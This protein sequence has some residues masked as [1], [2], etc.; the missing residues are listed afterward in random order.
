MLLLRVALGWQFLEEGLWKLDKRNNFSSAGY[1]SQAKGPLAEHYRS[2]VPD[3]YDWETL[4][5]VQPE[6]PPTSGTEWHRLKSNEL[7]AM[8]KR[9][10]V[11]N[12]LSE[13]QAKEKTEKP[14]DEATKKLDDLV[15]ENDSAI[16]KYIKD[17]RELDAQIDQAKTAGDHAK[18][19][20]LQAD[21]QALEDQAKSWKSKVAR[22]ERDLRNALPDTP[23]EAPYD[24]WNVG[25]IEAWND[26]YDQA[27][28]HYGYDEATQDKAQAALASAREELRDFFADEHEAV[29]EYLRESKALAES[30][31]ENGSKDVPFLQGRIGDKERELSAQATAWKNK[32]RA[33]E[34]EYHNKL[35]RLADGY[36]N[37]EA[38]PQEKTTLEKFDTFMSYSLVAIG[39]CLVLGLFTRLASLGG[40]VFLLNVA[41]AQPNFPWL[42]PPIHP[43]IGHSLVTKEVVEML[44]MAFMACTTIGRV[45]GVDFFIHALVTGRCCRKGK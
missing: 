8:R 31:K 9:Y 18:L 41:L 34:S 40:A 32:V 26:F 17:S 19:E 11:F 23:A 25:V 27:V 36:P 4:V 1:L 7:R 13:E 38:V 15:N 43:S 12:G 33:L 2:M 16:S 6:D 20:T 44:V 28:E 45:A 24:Q 21:Q 14:L 39:G 29:D 35:W 3:Y 42:G 22:I 10:V 5:V 30:K 37:V